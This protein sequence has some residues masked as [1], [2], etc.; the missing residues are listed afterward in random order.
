[1]E[2]PTRVLSLSYMEIKLPKSVKYSSL[3]LI[4]LVLL[5]F[6]IKGYYISINSIA[7]DEP[8][9]IFH[10]KL[11]LYT[12]IKDLSNGNNPPLYEILLHFWI[13][14]VGISAPA[15]RLLSLIFSSITVI[16]IYKLGK[17]FFNIRVAIYTALLF[18]FSNY[19][20]LF[21]HEARVYALL[22]L[23][24]VMSMYYFLKIIINNDIHR[25]TALKLIIVNVAL[26]YAHYFGFWILLIQFLYVIFNKEIRNKHWEKLLLIGGVIFLLYIPNCI[27]FINRF[28]YSSANGTWLSPVSDL[29]NLHT[30]IHEFS[31]GNTL[32][33]LVLLFIVWFSAGVYVSKSNFNT[34]LKFAIILF[35]FPIFYMTG[36][37]IFVSTPYI[38]L[39]TREIFYVFAFLL[40]LLSF[41]LYA[42]FNRNTAII[43]TQTKV[44]VFWFWFP[45]LT[46]F[47]LSSACTIHEFNFM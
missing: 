11:D 20:I 21:A 41:V 18:I 2:S 8:F 29:G 46:M 15:V 12:I 16:F 19:Q 45:F 24:S 25:S 7:G 28:I 36:A 26:V 37:S 34:I 43:N 17:S 14:I 40:I 10:A 22:G 32:V 35:L 47:I 13:K 3:I 38:Y 39:L 9:S 42:V 27:V 31:N 33:Y 4:S 30:I 23:L 5:N 6:I 44:V 1:M